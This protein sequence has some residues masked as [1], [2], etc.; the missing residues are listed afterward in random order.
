ME[1]LKGSCLCGKVKLEVADDFKYMGS[2]HCSECRKFTGSDYSSAGGIALDKLLVTED[3][4]HIQS[5]LKSENTELCFC[6]QWVQ[7]STRRRAEVA[8][9]EHNTLNRAQSRCALFC[10]IAV[11]TVRVG[12]LQS[13]QHCADS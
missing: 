2:C 10:P 6:R 5:Y 13:R 7:V 12:V 1:R 3:K 8:F 11:F 9:F 4:E